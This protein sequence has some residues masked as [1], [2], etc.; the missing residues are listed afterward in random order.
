MATGTSYSREKRSLNPEHLNA[1]R[2]LRREQLHRLNKGDYFGS[3]AAKVDR[4]NLE[5]AMQEARMARELGRQGRERESLA[6][7]WDA[8]K[9]R[10]METWDERFASC[11]QVNHERLRVLAESQGHARDE[12][13]RKLQKLER[14]AHY[15]MSKGLLE[16]SMTEKRLALDERFD[17]AVA[18]K[19]RTDVLRSR[20]MAQHSKAVAAKLEGQRDQLRSAQLAETENLEQR[21]HARKVALEREKREAFRVLRQKYKN[22]AHDAE[23]AFVMEFKAPP[24]CEILPTA[25]H[26][27]RGVGST[28]MGT[29]KLTSFAGAKG[30][31]PNLSELPPP[32]PEDVDADKAPWMLRES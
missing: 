18:V 17:E 12:L 24:A 3:H 14:S 16:Y 4:I 22:L 27:G 32:P 23:H 15:R 1:V 30:T 2:A 5:A 20:E 28:F 29:W 26:R 13:D 10:F 7:A 25:A 11:V 21:C 9:A 8:E 31:V 6:K 19:K